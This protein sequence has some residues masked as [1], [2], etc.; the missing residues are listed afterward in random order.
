M[1][2]FVAS[3]VLF[4]A[5]AG[6]PDVTVDLR[7]NET[8]ETTAAPA[9]DEPALEEA[10]AEGMDTRLGRALS[11]AGVN[12]FTEMR[13]SLNG[14]WDFLTDPKSLNQVL[15]QVHI[16]WASIFIIVGGLCVLNGYR[17]HKGLILVLAAIS[18]IYAGT[19]LGERIGGTNVVAACAAV[20]FAV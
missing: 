3:M 14:K 13:K 11:G 10:P 20:L 16:V 5:A 2:H 8:V 15:S 9:S 12:P 18:G 4:V 6:Q 17:W 1:L 19:V 7:E